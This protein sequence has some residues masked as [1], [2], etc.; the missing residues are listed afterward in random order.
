M[1]P[2]APLG[3]EGHVNDLSLEG[4]RMLRALPWRDYENYAAF[5]KESDLLLCPVLSDQHAGD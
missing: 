3:G 5:L 4:D 1:S 2:I